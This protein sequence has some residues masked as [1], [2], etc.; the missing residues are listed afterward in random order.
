[1]Q[2]H[3]IAM[4]AR[5]L[6]PG[7]WRR[8]LEPR[9]P[10]GRWWLYPPLAIAA[11]YY[12]GCIPDAALAAA[13]DACRPWLRHT[14][15]GVTLTQV[16]WSNLRISAFPGIAWSSSP[17]EALR[18]VRSRVLPDRIA[19]QELEEAR[20]TMPTLDRIPWYG[21]KHLKRIARWVFSRPP[22]VQTMN[23]LMTAVADEGA[24]CARS[25]SRARMS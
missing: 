16:S 19:L 24:A 6:E 17:V 14:Q 4:L 21:E 18:F 22:R 15:R 13:R 1:V 2:I 12:T 20:H 25:E 10:G 9:R 8:L 23:S 3:D 11:D 7:E 5:R